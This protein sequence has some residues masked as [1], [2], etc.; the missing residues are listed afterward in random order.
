MK[1][2]QRDPVESLQTRHRNLVR[3][4]PTSVALA[5]ACNTPSHFPQLMIIIS[6]E[7]KVKLLRDN[8]LVAICALIGIRNALSW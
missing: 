4:L 2:M 5:K 6:Q 3:L 1:R 8:L 7:Q